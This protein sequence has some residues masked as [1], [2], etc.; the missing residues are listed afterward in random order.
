MNRL[1]RIGLFAWIITKK[2]LVPVSICVIAFVIGF[3]AIDKY[4]VE[5]SAP[6]E[7]V[8][9]TSFNVPN[10]REGEDV[11]FSVCR[12]HKEN[13][14]FTGNLDVYVISPDNGKPV[15]TFARDVGG[16]LKNDCDNKVIKAKDFHHSPGLYEMQFC[17][18]IRVR[19]DIKKTICK[20]SN[21]YKIYA[22]PNDLAS[23]VAKLQLALAEAQARYEDSV[24]D[25]DVTNQPDTLS[26][27]QSSSGDAADPQ[28][29]SQTQPT[30]AVLKTVEKCDINQI[31]FLPI[32][33][34]CRQVPA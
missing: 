2:V 3:T 17:I 6:E 5:K 16:H 32:K 28:P 24:A 15:K 33:V 20:T 19:Y 10:A 9:Y 1:R 26:T 29:S 27:S 12:D 23:E 18:D 34:N 4:N 14:S 30:P 7:Y 11:Y 22:Q 8:N 21:N 13:Y 31:L 25:G